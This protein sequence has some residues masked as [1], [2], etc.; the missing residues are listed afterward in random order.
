VVIGYLQ[1]LFA[2]S[3]T[4]GSQRFSGPLNF[5]PIVDAAPFYDHLFCQGSEAVE[6]LAS[7]GIEGAH[8]LP[9]ACDPLV[10]RPVELTVEEQEEYGSDVSFIGSYYQSRAE[11]FEGLVR[12]DFAIWGPGWERLHADSDLR[13][14]L[15][16]TYL[17]PETWVKIYSASKIILAPHFSEP[18]GLFPVYQASPRVFEALACG[19]FTI[20][21]NQRDVFELFKDGLHLVR[22]YDWE[23]LIKK[24]EYYLEHAER[25]R[26][27]SEEG[28]R[29]V[30]ANHTYEH[31]I[32]EM[33][34]LIKK[35]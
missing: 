24:I 6:L 1:R 15:K 8:W 5:Q 30:L 22:F 19:A 32:N 9:M 4:K 18:N 27:I 26:Y 23:D 17:P 13:K 14:C 11:L 12:F 31:R 28:Q 16:G 10:H 25:R 20:S 3:R 2:E 7:A 35:R 21:D 33:L 34:G 29:E